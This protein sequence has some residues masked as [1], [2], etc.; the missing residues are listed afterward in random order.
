MRIPLFPLNTVLFPGMALPLHIF[1][2]RY[3]RMINTC[4]E[5]SQPFGVVLIRSGPEVGGPAEIHPIGT[6]AR[7]TSVE[8]LPG[9]R[10]NIE[11]AGQERF[12]VLDSRVDADGVSAEVESFPLTRS[13]GD[14]DERLA[15]ALGPWLTRYLELLS[16]AAKTPFDQ[17][18]LPGQPVALAYL[19]A[20]VVQVPLPDKQ[21]LLSAPT[22]ADM[23]RQERAL[24]RRE[25]GF[26]RAMLARHSEDSRPEGFSPN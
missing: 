2:P 19:A 14:D 17:P 10:M 9:G 25:I 16:R 26:L 3:Q 4:L 23:L 1:E 6:L 20:I 11:T 15:G 22:A 21:A 13:S 7:I 18:Q 8:R 12:R 5:A 24:F